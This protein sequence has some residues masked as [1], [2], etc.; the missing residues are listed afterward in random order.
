MSRDRRRLPAL[1]AA[2]AACACR[3]RGARACGALRRLGRPTPA[4]AAAD[5]APRR[6]AVRR[7]LPARARADAGGPGAGPDVP[8]EPAAD[9][10]GMLFLFDRG[11]AAPLLDEEHDDPARH[12]LDGRG[13]QGPLRLRRHAAVQGGSLPDLRPRR[14]RRARCSRSREARRPRKASPWARSS[15][16][17][18]FRTRTDARSS[19]RIQNSTPPSL[20]NG[21][22]CSRTNAATSGARSLLEM[23][24]MSCASSPEDM[25]TVRTRGFAASAAMTSR[26]ALLGLVERHLVVAD[27][28][29]PVE[30]IVE[31]RGVREVEPGLAASRRSASPDHPGGRVDQ[32]GSPAR[33]TPRPGRGTAPDL[34]PAG[35][36]RRSRDG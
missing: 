12:D 26:W 15:G 11:R 2:L 32:R 16:S 35:L 24:S 1:F 9:K 30:E 18:T 7:R 17:R 20:E 10:T 31:A 22:K 5:R 34:R 33:R 36:R 13:R 28:A 4:P 25:S 19:F 6:P 8:R 14:R 23:W 29:I 3:R 27:R 21:R